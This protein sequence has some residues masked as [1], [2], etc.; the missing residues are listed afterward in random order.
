MQRRLPHVPAA[1]A[2]LFAVA[3]L[4]VFAAAPAFAEE[5]TSRMRTVSGVFELS[6][7]RIVPISDAY[8]AESPDDLTPPQ[9]YEI[10]RPDIML[11]LTI[12]RLFTSCS[13]IRLES[14][15]RTF[16]SG[17]R[18]VV[19]L[20]NIKD[21]PKA[22]QMYAFF[23]QLREP[24]DTTLRFDTFVQTG[25]GIG[26]GVPNGTAEGTAATSED[27]PRPATAVPGLNNQLAAALSAIG[28][29]AAGTLSTGAS[30]AT[31]DILNGDEDESDD[32]EGDPEPGETVADTEATAD[33][34][35]ELGADLPDLPAFD[36]PPAA[37]AATTVTMTP[38]TTPAAATEAPAAPAAA[39]A[40]AA[41][42]LSEDQVLQLQ[43][44]ALIQAE[45][46]AKQLARRVQD[47]G[48]VPA[49]ADLPAAP[50]VSSASA[51]G[52]PAAGAADLLAQTVS[53]ITIGVKDMPASIRFY[54]A[55]GWQRAA[56]GKY[57]Q[58]A[59]FQ[60]NGQVL[61]LYP[62]AAL[63]AEQNME[64]AAPSP[65]GITLA[66]H[67]KNKDSVVEIYQRFLNAGGKSLRAPAEM[68]SGA[69]SSYVAD[70]DGNPWEISWVPQF[71]L[72][73]TGDLWLP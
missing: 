47:L 63:L 54:E 71:T 60:L 67:V 59:F 64:D 40:P 18:A 42:P 25:V 58:T 21:T 7:Y 15:K 32:A 29:S 55:I 1:M 11:P 22:G 9:A 20:R 65:G 70:P 45:E 57:D 73:A 4:V 41:T 56:R 39:A 46:Q 17:E 44:L 10:V 52:A 5:V 50:S 33:L 28:T 14:E 35:A 8:V 36:A 49:D 69:V 24:V 37:A 66:L 72:D 23:V 6:G 3:V 62:V 30:E 68:A 13:C 43:Q 26:D 12:G 19:I 61:A 34:A 2:A 31:G 27:Y 38:A 16:S 53:L 51:G 48:S